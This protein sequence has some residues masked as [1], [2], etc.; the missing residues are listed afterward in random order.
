M[1]APVASIR[2]SPL[3]ESIETPIARAKIPQMRAAIHRPLTSRNMNTA[4]AKKPPTKRSAPD[5]ALIQPSLRRISVGSSRV[6]VSVSFSHDK[7]SPS[8]QY[9]SSASLDVSISRPSASRLLS[10]RSLVLYLASAMSSGSLRVLNAKK[11]VISR[12]IPLEI[13]KRSPMSHRKVSISFKIVSFQH[14]LVDQL[15]RATSRYLCWAVL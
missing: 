1:I 5:T 7:S 12:A 4:R 9:S 8:F 3:W 13:R 15:L 10:R 6:I 11:A 2:P 14:M